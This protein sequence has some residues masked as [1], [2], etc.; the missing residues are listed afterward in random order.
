MEYLTTEK[1]ASPNTIVSYQRDLLK[2]CSYLET[3]EID[4]VTDVTETNLN[5]YILSLETGGLAASS[6]SRTIAS[7]RAFFAYLDETRTVAKNVARNLKAPQIE[8]KLPSVLEAEEIARLLAIPNGNQP[9]TMRDK[10]MLELMYATGIRVTE[11]L[12]MKVE[13]VDVKMGYIVI[14][15]AQKARVV[16]V[17]AVAMQSVEQYLQM[18]RPLLVKD[19]CPYLFVNY[20]GKPMTRQGFWKIVKQYADAAGIEKPITP[21]SLR[22]SFAVHLVEHGADLKSLQELM[23]YSSLAAAQI[24][25]NPQ[26]YR[27]KEVYDKAHIRIKEIG[28]IE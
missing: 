23:G 24:Y 3:H 10:A 21:S 20:A 27:L 14:P 15:A 25:Q 12:Q 11:L 19:D 4:S 13:D 9:K 2:L 16:P 26:P 18:A 5:S 28:E 7:I 1:H 8:R 17:E 6:I 22:H